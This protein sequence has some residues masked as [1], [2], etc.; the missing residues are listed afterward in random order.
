LSGTARVVPASD[1]YGLIG[2]RDPYFALREVAIAGDGT[3]E[4]EVPIEQKSEREASVITAAEAARHMGL[5]GSVAAAQKNA[6][7]QLHYYLAREATLERGPALLTAAGKKLEARAS[8]D[9]DFNAAHAKVTLHDRAGA[10]LYTLKADYTILDQKGFERI[11]SGVKRD[12]RKAARPPVND[13]RPSGELRVMRANP[14]GAPL[15]LRNMDQAGTGDVAEATFGPIDASSCTG[16][17]PM[18]PVLPVG[19]VMS[20]LSQLCGELLVRRAGEEV[21]YSVRYAAA[22]ADSLAVVGETVRFE[23]RY[24]SGSAKT[25]LFQCKARAGEKI[26]GQMALT[27]TVA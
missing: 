17:Y 19:I 5:L 25:R 23:A 4:A 22:T 3:V 6:S 2:V 11:F 9:L 12:M 26:V 18:H 16:H 10:L 13:Q 8:A 15:E 24:A 20:A 21:K 14:Y 1:L 7:R 27:L